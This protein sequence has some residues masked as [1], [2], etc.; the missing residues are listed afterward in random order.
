MLD[1]VIVT[2]SNFSRSIAFYQQVLKPLGITDF[3][4]LMGPDGHPDPQRFRK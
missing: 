4:N 2:V 1:Y 3:Q